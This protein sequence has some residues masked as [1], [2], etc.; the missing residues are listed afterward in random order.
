MK[1]Q[2]EEKPPAVIHVLLL[3]VMSVAVVRHSRAGFV[4]MT[5]WT[6]SLRIAAVLA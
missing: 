1:Q 4:D 6:A 2:T 5:L 3:F